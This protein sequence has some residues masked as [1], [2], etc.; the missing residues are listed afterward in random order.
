MYVGQNFKGLSVLLSNNK[1]ILI[2]ENE[3][4]VLFY[5][6]YF[7]F[8]VYYTKSLQGTF[9]SEAKLVELLVTIFN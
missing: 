4:H 1:L 5:Y 9:G 6:Y 3:N 2:K 7:F 8:L